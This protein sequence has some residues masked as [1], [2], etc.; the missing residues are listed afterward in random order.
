MKRQKI[1]ALQAPALSRDRLDQ[2]ARLGPWDREKD[3]APTSP[4]DLRRVALAAA[5]R[6]FWADWESEALASIEELSQA[7]RMRCAASLAMAADPNRVPR[8]PGDHVSDS[9]AEAYGHFRDWLVEMHHARLKTYI[10]TVRNV[11]VLEEACREPG[12]FRMAVNLHITVRRRSI[13]T[14]RRNWR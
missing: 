5:S 4:D 12:I 2:L 11:I 10:G 13:G 8:N 3:W 1:K 9:D 6:P 14:N 7:F